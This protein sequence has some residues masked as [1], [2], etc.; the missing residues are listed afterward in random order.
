MKV[1]VRLEVEVDPK[2][3]R[4]EYNTDKTAAE[5]KQWIRYE[6]QSA[7]ESALNVIGA[8]VNVKI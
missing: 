7:T 5:I 8:K 1:I 3:I 4:A 2:V 6:A